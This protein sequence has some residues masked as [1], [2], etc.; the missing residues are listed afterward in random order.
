MSIF[1]TKNTIVCSEI[2]FCEKTPAPYRNQSTDLPPKSTNWFLYDTSYHRKV[3]PNRRHVKIK[4]NPKNQT[5]TCR[6]LW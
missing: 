4:I 5:L 6:A 3:F 1:E 2:H